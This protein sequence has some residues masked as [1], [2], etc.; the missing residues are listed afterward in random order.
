MTET[1]PYQFKLTL[2]QRQK[3]G[4]VYLLILSW[5]QE[6]ERKQAKQTDLRSE[7]GQENDPIQLP[8]SASRMEKL[9]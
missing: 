7:N 9:V 4:Q 3:L 6:R 8:E 2:E 5:R 1:A